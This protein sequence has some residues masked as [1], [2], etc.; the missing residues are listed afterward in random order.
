MVGREKLGYDYKD[1]MMFKNVNFLIIDLYYVKLYYIEIIKKLGLD[2][3][4]K[5]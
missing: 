2:L 4:F 3:G 1:V 5:R